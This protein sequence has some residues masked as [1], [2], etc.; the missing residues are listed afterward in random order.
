MI[1][2]YSLG[3]AV[4]VFLGMIISRKLSK[5]LLSINIVTKLPG[6]VME[7][8]LRANKFGVTCYQGSGKDGN[9]KVLNVICKAVDFVKLK[10]IVSDIDK[11]A[12]LTS[13]AIE[14]LYGGFIFNIKSRI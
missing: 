13:Q 2:F 6:T 9:L 1:L 7:D 4:G 5:Y 10:E 11:K 14:G 12:M 8:L 3:V